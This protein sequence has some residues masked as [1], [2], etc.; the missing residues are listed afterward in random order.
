M[1]QLNLASRIL[2]LA[3]KIFQ[4]TVYESV[5]VIVFNRKGRATEASE[6]SIIS[7]DKG[8]LINL[9]NSYT[10]RIHPLID[11]RFKSG[12]QCILLK[13]NDELLHIAW[14]GYRKEITASYE[15][16]E[17]LKI[18]ARMPSIVIY[19]CW[20]PEKARGQGAYKTILN[21]ISSDPKTDYWIYC[22]STNKA[23][24]KGILKA[25]FKA[26]HVMNKRCFFGIFKKRSLKELR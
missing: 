16:G 21:L 2:R 23:S 12:D 11:S 10:Q 15:I 7:I 9:D 25:G 13:K 4:R 19:D 6:H 20:T 5:D 26:S 24:E 17:E 22:L 3:Q 1:T 18:P 8:A 14:I